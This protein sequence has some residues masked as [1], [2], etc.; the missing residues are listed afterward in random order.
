M[1]HTRMCACVI[2]FWGLRIPIYAEIE[3]V[4]VYK[5]RLNLQKLYI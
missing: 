3:G 2:G 4:A 5:F 1:K